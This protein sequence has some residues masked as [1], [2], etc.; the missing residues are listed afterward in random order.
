[1]IWSLFEN[2]LHEDV[3]LLTRL[4]SRKINQSCSFGNTSENNNRSGRTLSVW[5]MKEKLVCTVFWLVF[6]VKLAIPNAR[7][8]EILQL[9]LFVMIS[10]EI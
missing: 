4:D 2:H 9:I 10:L 8:R 1:M 6:K 5:D 3:F 7:F